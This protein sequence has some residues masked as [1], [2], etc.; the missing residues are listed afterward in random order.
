MWLLALILLVPTPQLQA[1]CLV[2]PDLSNCKS[3]VASSFRLNGRIV[4]DK[5]E[6]PLVD[7]R[8]KDDRGSVLRTVQSFANGTFFFD[9]VGLG[10]YSVEVADARFEMVTVPLWLRDPEDSSG[11]IIIRLKPNTGTKPPGPG[12][13]DLDKIIRDLKLDAKVP[14]AALDEFAK[15]A[16]AISRRSKNDSP[17]NH[18]KEA[19]AIY[20]DFYEAYYQLGLEQWRQR[21]TTDAV[22]SMSHAVVLRPTLA[23]PLSALGHFYVDGGEFQ[24]AVDTLLKIGAVGSFTASDRYDLGVAFLKLDNAEAAQQNLELAISLAPGQNPATYVQL[25]NAYSRNGNTAAAL[26][27]L[28]D[29]LRLFP[30]ERNHKLVEDAAKKL[31]DSISKTKP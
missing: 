26:T 30:K 21:Q 11:L 6:L 8:L 31:R 13:T 15:G 14:A 12:S 28:E 24:K 16:E 2:A 25:A 18:F 5:G 22:Q 3:A 23:A 9:S 10:R 29:Y 19:I 20:P 1:P 27:S 4:L 7:V 17:E